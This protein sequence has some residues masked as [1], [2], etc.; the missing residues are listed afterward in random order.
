L[1]RSFVPAS[2]AA[3]YVK[4]GVVYVPV[5]DIPPIQVCLGW[6]PERRSRFVDV[7]VRAVRAASS[8][9]AVAR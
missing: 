7:F 9:P 3:A 8:G 6:V 2:A 5:A 4:Q 1:C